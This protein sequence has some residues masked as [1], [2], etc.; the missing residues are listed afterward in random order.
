MKQTKLNN[1]IFGK[2]LA[3]I[4]LFTGLG[5]KAQPWTPLSSGTNEHL[6]SLHFSDEQTGY[7][8]GYGGVILKTN[9]GGTTWT[10]QASGTT[11]RFYSTYFTNALNGWAV[12]DAGTIRHTTDGGASWNPVF[13]PAGSVDLRVVWFLNPNVGF[14]AGG[15][16]GT[17]ATIL[18]TTDGGATWVDVSPNTGQAIYGIYFTSPLVGYASDFNGLMLKTT[19]GGASW[20]SQ[21]VSP[22]NLHSIYFTDANTGYVA[23]GSI[24]GNSGVILKTTNAGATWTQHNVPQGFLTDIKFSSPN[25]GVAVGGNLAINQA[26]ILRTTD[27]GNTWAA[28]TI[29]PSSSSR[30]FRVFLPNAQVGFSCGLDGTILRK[31]DAVQA[32]CD[33]TF[34]KSLTNMGGS[35]PNIFPHPNGDFFATGKR[36]DSIVIARFDQGGAVL[37]ARTFRLGDDVLQI[38]DMF[39]DAS[40]DLIGV[41]FYET[42]FL[43]EIRSAVFRYNIASHSFV[44]VRYLAGVNYFNIHDL[45]ANN[46]VL[47]GTT[48]D[49]LTHLIQLDKSSGAASGYNLVGEGGDYTSAVHNGTLYG[50]C[51]RYYNAGGD[52]RASV[53]AHNLNSG[54]FLWQNSIISEGNTSSFDETRM[55]PVAPV[56]DNNGILVLASGDLQGFDV[57]LDGPVELVLAKTNLVGDVQWTKQYVIAGFDRPV[58]T[59]IAPT[60]TGYYIVGN[61]YA[62]S[63]G[64]FA[65]S[66]LIKTDKQ[67]QVQWAKRLG[68]SG[69]NIAK[70]VEE[71]NGF[72]YLTMASDSYSFNDLLLVKLDQNGDT[73]TGCEFVQPISVDVVNLAN[74]QHDRPYTVYDSG[75]SLFLQ[76]AISTDAILETVTYCN[77]PCDCSGIYASLGPDITTCT[78]DS[79]QLSVS[80]NANFT[81]FNWSPATGISCDHCPMPWVGPGGTGEY[82]LEASTP[83]GCV[84]RD[85]I[86]I[87]FNQPS[88]V[89][90]DITQCEN[91]PFEYNGNV[92]TMDGTY[93][94]PFTGI[95]GCDSLV[96]IN[97]DFVPLPTRAQTIAFCAGESVVIGGNTYTQAG[98][99]MQTI[100]GT[101]ASC[102]TVVT[103]TLTVL[104]LPTRAVPPTCALPRRWRF[105]PPAPPAPR[106]SALGRSRHRARP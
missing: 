76:S 93:T 90:L 96:T 27:A 86:K 103:Y 37:W 59:A 50:T 80:G 4:L 98:I 79:L 6:I 58:A 24:G 105:C 95:N 34:I 69:K 57:F 102:D 89:T 81:T 5:I 49:A 87:V 29:T 18:K 51:R 42:P 43:S 106:W 54:A 44:W 66:V 74:I 40:D 60:A 35:Q 83:E 25:D 48:A 99:V 23:G 56:I 14:I 94:F 92:Y 85:T 46:F 71:R 82:F 31:M 20:S 67:G 41:A 7:V 2:F 3:L 64:N 65:Y 97:L 13:S 39:V 17:A 26:I 68:I 104:P 78:F 36:N 63:L 28:E 15:I 100:P 73:E 30:Q 22:N 33:N 45:D 8:V 77:T 101:G 70:N 62:P 88:S 61:L 16:S 32:P 19:N 9:N 12:G 91:E 38:R 72:L 75:I 11:D 55:Y 84:A 21:F 47:T 53:F 52:F 10:Q 1:S